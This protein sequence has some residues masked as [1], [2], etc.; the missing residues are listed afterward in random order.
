M[1]VELRGITKRFGP[2]TA[3]D[4]VNLTIRGGEVL[5]LLG[6]NGAGKSTMMNILSGLYSPDAGEIL[7]DGKPVVFEGPGDGIE[8]GIGM[9][10]QHFMLVPVFTV[11]ENVVLGV[12]PTGNLGYLDI[13]KA[14]HDVEEISTKYGLRVPADELIENLPVGIQQRVEILKVL[15][16]EA[17]VLILDEPTAVL[18]PQEVEEFFGIVRSLKE[19]GK[20]IVFITHKLHEILEI[21]DRIS[22]LRQGRI[23]GEGDP[24]TL[25]EEKLAEMMVG[26]HVSFT[27]EKAPAKPGKPMLELSNLVMLDDNDDFVLDHVTFTVPSGEVVGIAGVQGNGQ[28]EL[29]E[30]ITGLARIASGKI[31]FDGT[32]ITHASVRERHRMGMA[33]I[34]EDRHRSGM[35][36]KFTIAE[37]MV[38]NSYYDEEYARGLSIDWKHVAET[39]AVFCVDFD[40][41]TPS[42]FLPAG[43]LSGGNQQKMVVARELERE[44]KLV[45]ASQPT[46]GLDVGS[47]EYIHK[48]LIESRDEGDGV[49]IVSSELDEIMGLSDRILVMFEGRIVGEFDNTGGKADRNAVGLAMAG[50]SEGA[51]A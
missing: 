14:R 4:N 45:V 10:H 1:D 40:V 2:V 30:A 26:R 31:I 34:P 24:K 7:I 38:L 27:V 41:R 42:V 49:L 25:D 44:T 50:A 8:A 17:D 32:D 48:R 28:T 13:K 47:I 51:A 19:A 46:R 5:G 39:A 36:A 35:I 21:S 23:T 29:V 37:N 33:H 16:R 6:E 3:N 12:E 18:T 22:V 15:F 9:V 20:A 11:A 43:N